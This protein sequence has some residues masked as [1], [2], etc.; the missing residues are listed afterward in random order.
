[1][2]KVRIVFNNGQEWQVEKGARLSEVIKT[3]GFQ[4]DFPCGGQG[5]CGQCKIT[6]GLL[7]GIDR[8]QV[9]AC[10]YKVEKDTW[11]ELPEG[12]DNLGTRIL[13]SGSKPA[14][15][16]NPG[17]SKH[18]I[19][20]NVQGNR[21]FWDGL[22]EQV[23][24]LGYRIPRD[25]TILQHFAETGSKA[26]GLTLVCAGDEVIDVEPGDTT[27][28]LYGLAV[29]IGTT[30]V[31][32]YLMD[33]NTGEELAVSADLNA[34]RVFGADVIS[35]I[36]AVYQDKDNLTQL[37][38]KVIGTINGLLEKVIQQSEVPAENIYAV[39]LAGNTCMHHLALSLNPKNL[40]RSPFLPVIQ[41]PVEVYA[42]KLGLNVNPRARVWVF[43]VIAGFVG[44]DTVAAVLASGLHRKKGVNLLIDIGTNGELVV[45][46]HG[47]MA[48]CSAA[49][50][51]ALEGAQITFGMRAETGAISKVQLLPEIRLEIIG[52][53]HAKGICG[54]GLVDLL[55]ELIK[56]KLINRRGRFV[57]PE[58]YN[59]P[60]FLKE[61]L[62]KGD[63]GYYFVLRKAE[64]NGGREI[65][66]SQ[67][68]V[69]QLQLAKGA[70]RAAVELLV[71]KVGVDGLEVE[72][73]LL[74]GA[75]GNFLNIDQALVIG[76]LPEWA[77]G[78]VRSI[79]NAA[80]EGAK[81]ALLSADKRREASEIN[82][83]VEFLELA[84]TADFQGAFAQGMLFTKAV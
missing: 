79:G 76:L 33:L 52:Q 32:G 74:A 22:E 8:E 31:V 5:K 62:V 19:E 34:Q 58:D 21:S 84:G 70:L 35:R 13:S 50:G 69:S 27:G 63:K 36:N 49:A 41:H 44:G 38:M 14:F 67:E 17:F 26:K 25:L 57:A 60:Q 39:T 18:Y 24:G 46:A 54:S 9:L 15:A 4:M 78:K 40:G 16:L 73:V 6:I 42:H 72:E 45:N 30:T 66:F 11:V 29:D 56:A 28:A 12:L 71:E 64:E 75:F 68:D 48:A 20:G 7:N 65:Y 77:K 55:G 3:A 53:E 47:R 2:D 10:T 43:P 59:G 51:P 1:M 80:G 83:M 37:Q 82:R 81:M 23:R 61:R